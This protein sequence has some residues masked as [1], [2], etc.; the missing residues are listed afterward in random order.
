MAKI[1]MDTSEYEALKE[2]KTLLEK[3]LE[4]ERKL[5]EQITKLSDE[6]IKALEDAKM[7]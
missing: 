7:K 4:N 2:N 3:S 6:K 5:Q 1:T